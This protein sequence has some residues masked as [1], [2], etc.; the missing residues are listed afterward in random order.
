V[1]H[2]GDLRTRDVQLLDAPE[3]LLVGAHRAPPVGRDARDEQHVGR[4]DAQLEPVGH[5]LAQNARCER[6]EALAILDLEVHHRLHLRRTRVTDDAASAEGSGA[7]LH[8]ALMQ[9]D[10]LAGGE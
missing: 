2:G 6:P 9:A 8:P 10:D 3:V 4:V 5:V 7:E 1:G